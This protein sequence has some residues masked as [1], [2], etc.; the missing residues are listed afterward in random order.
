[1]PCTTVREQ[2]HTLSD[3]ERLA[4]RRETAAVLSH[5]VRCA[6]CRTYFGQLRR[7]RHATR[8]LPQTL[9]VPATMRGRVLAQLPFAHTPYETLRDSQEQYEAGF[10]RQAKIQRRILLA[11]V[12]GFS[13]AGVYAVQ[14]P[15]RIL[16]ILHGETEDD[17][18]K[19]AAF[20]KRAQELREIW[21]PWAMEHKKDLAMMLKNQRAA[22]N[23]IEKALPKKLT[24]TGNTTLTFES[25]DVPGLPFAYLPMMQEKNGQINPI[26]NTM[27]G[28]M[29]ISQSFTDP[30]IDKY[31]DIELL[32][33]MK[34]GKMYT[35]FVS[36]RIT[37]KTETTDIGRQHLV[38]SEIAPP[39]EELTR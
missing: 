36:G 4:N 11:A 8:H 39:Y 24:R 21:K 34:M 35:L 31:L 33:S 18:T 28:K 22:Y 23:R 7:L 3:G 32:C 19:N 25:L 26:R 1:M 37:E 5:C 30:A 13:F 29:R 9:A 6:E 16:A 2:L 27:G 14:N 20:I 17:P 15:G 12:L 10:R 38:S